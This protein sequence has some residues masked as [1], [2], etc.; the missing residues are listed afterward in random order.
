MLFATAAVFEAYRLSSLS[1]FERADIWWQLQTGNWIL[2][3]HSVPQTGLFFRWS[4]SGWSY[5]LLVAFA[6]GI[7]GLRSFPV[8]LMIFKS[9]FAALTLLLAGGLRGRFWL[10]VALSATAQYI[11]GSVP[12]GPTYCSILFFAVELLLLNQS[13]RTG[14]FRPLFW[15]LALFLVWANLDLQFVYGIAFLAIFLIV[16]LLQVLGHRSVVA[17][18]PPRSSGKK[19]D[20]I[21]PATVA[22]VAGL[23]ALATMASPYS[24]HLY[25]MFFSSISSASNIYFQ[26]SLPMHFK[27]PEDYLLLL[28]T[29]GAFLALGLRRSRDLFQ[30]ALLAGCAMLS[31]HAQRDAWLVVLAALAVIAPSDKHTG[32]P[33]VADNNRALN[34]Q[35]LIAG[36]LSILILLLAIALLIPASEESLLAKVAQTYPVDACNYI[37]QHQFPPPLFTSYEWGGFVLWY[38]PEY[39]LAIGGRA[40]VPY[41]DYSAMG[42][43]GTLLLQRGSLMERALSSLPAFR[44]T[45]R[46]RVAVV[47]SKP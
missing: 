34:R 9:A 4:V 46:D 47:L 31:F 37:R 32:V 13:R 25:G 45:Y 28:L 27:R 38:L 24:Y 23:C 22:I 21:P 7:L 33:A 6:T 12:A 8:L 29:M 26:D 2:Q 30:I 18:R 19:R 44:V 35:V 39:T 11:L 3:H 10:A 16:S 40:D 43:V 14:S 1:L 42:Q 41:K 15:L 36:G 20:P 17:G 5:D